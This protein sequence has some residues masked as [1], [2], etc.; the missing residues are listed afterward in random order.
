MWLSKGAWNCVPWSPR[1]TFC[2]RAGV[3]VKVFP[4]FKQ[5]RVHTDVGRGMM[6]L[7]QV[8]WVVCRENG[9]NFHEV[10]VELQQQHRLGAG[11]V[12]TGSVAL[13]VVRPAHKYNFQKV[14]SRTH[15]NLNSYQWFYSTPQ[16]MREPVRWKADCKRILRNWAFIGNLVREC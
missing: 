8:S 3:R 6:M 16:L 4:H 9:Q 13:V 15:I 10:V 11:P 2:Q 1:K 12:A 5:G 14:K 7:A